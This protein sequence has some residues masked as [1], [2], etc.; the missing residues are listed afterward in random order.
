MSV[1]VGVLVV[2]VGVVVGCLS[3][4]FGVGGGIVMVPFMVLALDESQH[5]AEGTSLMV[6]VPTAI[7][8][9]VA[10]RRRGYVSLRYGALLAAGGIAGAWV[11]AILALRLSGPDLQLVFNV[12]MAAVGVRTVVQGIRQMAKRPAVEDA[13]TNPT[14]RSDG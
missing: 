7:A 1:E 8:G 12:F 5:V 9:V 13:K 11:G 14:M 10:H 2:A 6:I 3:A 4:M